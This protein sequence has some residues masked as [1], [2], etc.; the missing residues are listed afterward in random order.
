[1]LYKRLHCALFTVPVAREGA[2]PSVRIDG[3]Q[4]AA[5]LAGVPQE[6]RSR[7]T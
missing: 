4:L 5:L 6:K 7:K 1:M 3:A 2:R